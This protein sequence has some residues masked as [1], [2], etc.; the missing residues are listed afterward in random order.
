MAGRPGYS[1]VI[2]LYVVSVAVIARATDNMP[3][4]KDVSKLFPLT[5]IHINDLHAR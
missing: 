4:N 5:L 1:E 3:V 2:F